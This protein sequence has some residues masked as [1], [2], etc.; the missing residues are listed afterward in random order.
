MQWIRRHDDHNYLVYITNTSKN[1]KKTNNL[2]MDEI[3]RLY[4]PG[5]RHRTDRV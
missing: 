3:G 5:G 4:L 2:A 1:K